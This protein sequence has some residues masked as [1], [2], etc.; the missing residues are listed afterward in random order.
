M[1]PLPVLGFLLNRL[2][3]VS[4]TLVTVTALIYGII[5]IAPIESRVNLYMGKRTRANMPAQIE[6]NM[7]EAIIREHGLDDPFP[8]QYVRWLGRL[9]RGE[10]GYSPLLR[11]DVLELLAKRSPATVEL[12]LYSLLLFLPL[13][14]I[15]GAIAGWRRGCAGD[16]GFRI[17]AYIAT[18]IPLFV[19]GLVL[20]SIFY[21]GLHWFLPGTLSS[22]AEVVVDSASFRTFTGLTTIDALLN[23]E[24]T[25]G[26]DAARH[27]VLPVVTLS[28]FHWAT[29]GRV[30]RALIIEESGKGYI[31][32][33]HAK[34]V[35]PRRILWGHAVP[36]VV[37]P[38]LTTSALSAAML[39]TG[40]YVVEIVFNWPGVSK[41]ITYTV[42]E[43][44]VALAAGF[45]VYS[46]LGVLAIMLTLDVLQVL[47]DPRL[48][49]GGQKT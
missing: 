10:W 31:T 34:G 45:S 30:T 1:K 14:L 39:I 40:V 26:L 35:A 15:F 5:N 29:L 12:T 46:V 28:L 13:G 27:L 43:P 23:G 41:L 24:W 3:I 20:L 7:I 33:A 16:R 8:V 32:A 17:V 42:H 37:A 49:S 22:R 25:V 48:R 18:S 9:V 2:V 19:L 38:A 11:A 6:Q 47:V 21:V 44:D 36:N 4:G